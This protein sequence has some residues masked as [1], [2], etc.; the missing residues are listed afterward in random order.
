VLSL[1]RYRAILL[2][3]LFALAA[4]VVAV[5]I[6]ATVDGARGAAIGTSAVEL[7]NA[8][9]GVFI[10]THRRSHLRP[11]MR[12]L[13]KVALALAFAA[14]PILL[15]IGEPAQ[16]ALSCLIYLIVLLVLRAPPSELLE[17]L[18]GHRLRRAG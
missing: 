17:L 5:S 3:N 9:I 18:P 8:I 14:T 2:F 10:L 13:P 11:S 4:V 15:P 6:G 16:V 7:G 1:E 12:V